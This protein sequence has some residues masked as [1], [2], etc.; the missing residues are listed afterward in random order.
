VTAPATAA[1]HHLH[2]VINH[3]GHLTDALPA[4]TTG[5]AY[6]IGLTAYLQHLDHADAEEVA[7]MREARAWQR[8]G[9]VALGTRP[10]PISL[11]VHDTMRAVEA[12]L[13]NLADHTARQVQRAP[14][15][16]DLARGWT[17]QVHR[18]VALLAARDAA[19][20]RRWSYTNPATRDAVHAA[21]WLLHR[22]DGA[23]GPFRPL[24]IQQT[25]RIT[26][27][28]AGAA[29][30]VLAALGMARRVKTAPHPCPHCRGTL[31]VHGGDGTD[32]TVRCTSPN[33]GWAR[34]ATDAAA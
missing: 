30:R 1:Q 34:T 24:H 3:W 10:V 11:K 26:Q 15:T 21:A 17:D 28:A 27:V 25:D 20:P 4:T 18:D 2:T 13:L 7:E 19:D 31:E 29:Q 32:P 22:L 14:V 33:C 9:T 6:G 23:P 12:V 16:V 5:T 8:A